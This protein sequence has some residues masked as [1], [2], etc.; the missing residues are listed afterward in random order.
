MGRRLDERQARFCGL[1]AEGI[2]PEEAARLA[3]YRKK[4][5]EK[6]LLASEK[7]RAEIAAATPRAEAAEESAGKEE[8]LGF[9]TGLMRDK[10]AADVK[11]R[12][13]AAEILGKRTGAF[14]KDNAA[15]DTGRVVIV[16][17]IP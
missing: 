5:V 7:I 2:A 12:M 15:E 13:R 16:D 14:E 11:T 1:C 10:K 9:L 17:D 8:I 3:G 6:N 4:G